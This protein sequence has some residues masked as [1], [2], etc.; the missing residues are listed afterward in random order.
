M[1]DGWKSVPLSEL[2]T[3]YSGGTPSKDEAA[4]W[5]GSVPWVTVKDMK[6]VRLSGVT[7]TLTEKGAQTVRV[8]P[9]GAVLVLVREWDYSKLAGC[10]VWRASDFQSGHQGS[11]AEDGVDS[12][13]LA[14]ALIA[15][16]SD[17]LRHVDSAGHG[18][19][20]LDTDLLRSTPLPFPR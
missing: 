16:K 8:V 9:S 2:A 3:F 1:L 14:F 7:E 20:R 4:Y 15:R 12:E 10:T 18:T 5:G 13:Y 11:C 19:G 17:I 6:T